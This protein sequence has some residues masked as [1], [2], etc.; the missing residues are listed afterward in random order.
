MIGRKLNAFHHAA[1]G[2][3]QRQIV[4]FITGHGDHAEDFMIVS[5]CG[6][7]QQQAHKQAGGKG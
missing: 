2:K 1:N 3:F 4:G 5:V 6:A 7:A